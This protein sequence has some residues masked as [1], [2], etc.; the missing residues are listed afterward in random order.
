VE[1]GRDVSVDGGSIALW[2]RRC[3]GGGDEL[4]MKMK[5]MVYG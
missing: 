4:M 1:H 5:T 3:V 2:W